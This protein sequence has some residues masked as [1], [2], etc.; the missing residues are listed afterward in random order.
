MEVTEWV[1]VKLG[2]AVWGMISSRPAKIGR[3]RLVYLIYSRNHATVEIQCM[4]KSSYEI[5]KQK[6]WTVRGERGRQR[7]ES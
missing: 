3:S 4:Y 7:S 1:Q 2:S 5:P 6:E